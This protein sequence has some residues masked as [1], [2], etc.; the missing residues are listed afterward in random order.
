[1]F[2]YTLS[3][4]TILRSPEPF[5]GQGPDVLFTFFGMANWVS[6]VDPAYHKITKFKWG[7]D[8]TY[9][10]FRWM[11]AAARFDM[12]EPNMN[13]DR[14]S[15]YAITANLIF[16]TAFVT[17]EQLVVGYTHY[18]YGS[19]VVPTYQAGF[20]NSIFKPDPDAVQIRAVMWW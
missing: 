4:A 1:M 10:F 6:S 7:A 2:Q 11:G 14:L 19:E 16:R 13:D 15:F 12:L 17:H 20:P 18:L 8:L 9:L 3:L 5:W